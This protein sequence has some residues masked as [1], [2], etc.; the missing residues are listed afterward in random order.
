MIQ[1]ITEMMAIDELRKEGELGSIFPIS[2]HENY[3]SQSFRELVEK[4]SSNPNISRTR[5]SITLID[6][7]AL[8][9][10]T[11]V[12]SGI[13]K[14]VQEPYGIFQSHDTAFVM[15]FWLVF[16]TIA[17]F[18]G[19]CY[20]ELGTR[21]P[22]SGG[23]KSYI[24]EILSEKLST[25]FVIFFV[26]LVKTLALAALSITGATYILN[27]WVDHPDTY[28]W[29]LRV[30][31]IVMLF[32]CLIITCIN[33]K[34]APKTG[35]VT[36]ILKTIAILIIIGGGLYSMAIGNTVDWNPPFKMVGFDFNQLGVAMLA[37]FWAYDGAN[38]LGMVAGE[39]VNPARDLPIA[40]IIGMGSVVILY[41]LIVISYPAIIGY[42]AVKASTGVAFDCAKKLLGAWAPVMS[43]L[44]FV[45]AFGSATSTLFTVSSASVSAGLT[46][47]LPRIFSIVN[48]KTRTPIFSAFVVFLIAS[49]MTFLDFNTILGYISLTGLLFYS[50]TYVA[51][52][53]I[54][55]KTKNQPQKGIFRVPY[56]LIIII[57][58]FY[59]FMIGLSFKVQ[60]FG[61]IIITLLML[62]VLGLQFIKLPKR[63]RVVRKISNIQDEFISCLQRRFGCDLANIQDIE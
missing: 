24:K 55:I 17:I 2:K 6:A 60:P 14:G 40:I 27:I 48:R 3:S 62:L 39:M 43:I 37:T 63:N 47:Q 59:L 35:V 22:Q 33:K 56:I 19:L 34:F 32:I 51:L 50:I 10:G 25:L 36:T 30:M 20:A 9:F 41:A 38:T 13:F 53:V 5:K 54:K 1:T 18:G 16:G 42:D 23:D 12:G 21:I 61:S 8:V 58:V 4:S 45:S 11:I 29:T 52:W 26:F 44:I 7:L 49:F 28:M 57:Q 46:G 31:A 15:I